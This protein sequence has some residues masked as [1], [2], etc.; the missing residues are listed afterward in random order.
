[1]NAKSISAWANVPLELAQIVVSMNRHRGYCD[2]KQ[3]RSSCRDT[4]T[5]KIRW[6]IAVE[7]RKRG[8]SYPAIGR[9][10]NRDHT[11]ILHAVRTMA[12]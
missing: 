5:V 7:A 12:A 1:M 9:A 4:D 2:L 6:Q 8:Y 11:S 3:L 10:L